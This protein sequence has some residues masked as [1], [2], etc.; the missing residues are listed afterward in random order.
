[1]INLNKKRSIGIVG[2]VIAVLAIGYAVYAI[3]GSE[4]PPVY[5]LTDTSLEISAQ[6]GET[7]QLSDILGVKLE[8]SMPDNLVKVS[9]ANMGSILRGSFR[10]DGTSM[11]IYVDTSVPPFIYLTTTKGLVIIN[12]QSASATRALIGQIQQN[13]MPAGSPEPAS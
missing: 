1:M 8:D 5:T 7:I 3:I 10:S 9:G 6:F 13:L 4:K 11:K 2:V 12:D